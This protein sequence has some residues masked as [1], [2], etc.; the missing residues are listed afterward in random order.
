MSAVKRL[1]SGGMSLNKALKH[2]GVSR[3]AYY[4]KKRPVERG[5]DVAVA[6]AVTR[7]A[8]DRPT[9]GTRMLAHTAAYEMG[10][11]V[12]RKKVRRIGSV[13]NSIISGS[14]NCPS[15]VRQRHAK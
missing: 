14:L 1:V 15:S 2:C 10:R 12:N 6:K 7:I 3:R 13:Q 4:Y 9:Y 8:S 11:P 5:I